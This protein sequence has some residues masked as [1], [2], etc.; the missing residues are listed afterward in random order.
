MSVAL[1]D[2]T[3]TIKFAWLL[4]YF[5]LLFCL[6]RW[7]TLHRSSKSYKMSMCEVFFVI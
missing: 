7:Q 2:R 3:L 1:V 5:W 6:M 4:F